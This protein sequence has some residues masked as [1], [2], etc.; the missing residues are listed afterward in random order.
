MI[1]GYS[2]YLPR[3]AVDT[4]V[5]RTIAE[6][7]RAVFNATA[8]DKPTNNYSTTGLNAKLI[9]KADFELHATSCRFGVETNQRSALSCHP[10]KY[11]DT[12]FRVSFLTPKNVPRVNWRTRNPT[13]EFDNT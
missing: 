9:P 5:G 8:L 11:S 1:P 6:Q 10:G 13:V 4:H 7:T 12:T 3:L 2:G